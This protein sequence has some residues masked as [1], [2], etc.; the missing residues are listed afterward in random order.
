MGVGGNGNFK[1]NM[2]VGVWM[3]GGNL[4]IIRWEWYIL[5]SGI[6]T[7]C[8][9]QMI[10]MVN[11]LGYLGKWKPEEKRSFSKKWTCSESCQTS[12]T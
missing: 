10:S 9:C 3:G 4:T 12:I 6:S 5:K 2:G 1:D 8:R 7:Y 11:T